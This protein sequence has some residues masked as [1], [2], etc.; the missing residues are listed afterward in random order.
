MTGRVCVHSVD[1]NT[2]TEL[3]CSKSDA[4]ILSMGIDGSGRVWLGHQGGLVQVWC[5]MYHTLITQESL[6]TSANVRSGCLAILTFFSICMARSPLNG[7]V[8]FIVLLACANCVLGSLKVMW[9]SLP[10]IDDVSHLPFRQWCF[11]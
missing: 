2:T 5:S 7:L 9:S 11:A 8:A 10:N 4:A 3:L 1:D 6:L